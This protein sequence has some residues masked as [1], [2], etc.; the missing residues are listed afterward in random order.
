MLLKM[1][2]AFSQVC[3]GSYTRLFSKE[4]LTL[5][6]HGDSSFPMIVFFTGSTPCCSFS[7]IFP[8]RDKVIPVIGQHPR[9][10]A[11]P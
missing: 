6:L 4:S 5:V 9:Y 10:G 2:D 11:V 1:L 3:S 7:F 8:I